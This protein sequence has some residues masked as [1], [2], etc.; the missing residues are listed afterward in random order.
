MG[1]VEESRYIERFQ[2]KVELPYKISYVGAAI[3]SRPEIENKIIAGIKESDLQLKVNQS[4][5]YVHGADLMSL[6]HQIYE[7]CTK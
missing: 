6:A 5:Y 2:Q 1:K 3:S 4:I 7:R